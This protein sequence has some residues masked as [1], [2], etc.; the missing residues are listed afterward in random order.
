MKKPQLAT[1]AGSSIDDETYHLPLRELERRRNGQA[2]RTSGFRLREP[3]PKA[4][5]HFHHFDLKDE[6]ASRFKAGVGRPI[7]A[8]S[9]HANVSLSHR[10]QHLLFHA[11]WPASGR[12]F[13]CSV[14]PRRRYHRERKLFAT[15]LSQAF[16]LSL[17]VREPETRDSI[18]YSKVCIH[19]FMV[20][21]HLSPDSPHQSIRS[22]QTTEN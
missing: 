8:A 4:P 15:K 6:L 3:K 12:S 1:A 13:R 18:Q 2:G 5:S 22:S 16:A 9:I 17:Q 11:L 10:P 20:H 7:S 14:K 19:V 21:H